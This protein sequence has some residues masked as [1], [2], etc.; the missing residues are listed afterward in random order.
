MF[1]GLHFDFSMTFQ[2]LEQNLRIFQGSHFYRVFKDFQGNTNPVPNLHTLY[3]TKCANHKNSYKCRAYGLGGVDTRQ[4]TLKLARTPLRFAQNE[5]F[6]LP[7]S[8]N[9]FKMKPNRRPTTNTLSLR[10][11]WLIKVAP[12]VSIHAPVSVRFKG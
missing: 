3:S 8:Q 5:M 4:G 2:V 6:I 11:C 9:I 12:S 7:H 10:G 1:R